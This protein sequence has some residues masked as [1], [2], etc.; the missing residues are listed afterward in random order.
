MKTK[1]LITVLLLVLFFSC[2]EEKKS[3]VVPSGKIPELSVSENLGCSSNRA[4]QT[5]KYEKDTLFYQIKNDT[6]IVILNF[7]KNCDFQMED[8]LSLKLDTVDILV[9]INGFGDAGCVCDFEFN[10]YF[11]DYGDEVHFNVFTRYPGFDEIEYTFWN[12]LTYP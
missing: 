5:L 10:Y 4:E 3:D 9:N 6:L 8:S 11:T 1:L 12:G 2:K 7:F